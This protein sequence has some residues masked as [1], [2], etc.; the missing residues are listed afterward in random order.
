VAATPAGAAKRGGDP[1]RIVTWDSPAVSHSRFVDPSAAPEGYYQE[2]PGVD[3]RPN[4]LKADVYLPAGYATHPD[5]RYP[6]LWLLHGH[7]DS[8]DA[9]PNAGDG[10]LLNTAAGFPGLIVMPEGDHGWYAN[11]WNGGAGGD[12][13]W[14]RYHLDQL[15]PYAN[16]RLRIRHGRR[17]H[18]IAGLSMG[19]LGAMYYASQ[20]PGYFASAASF[21]GVLSQERPEWATGFNTQGEDFDTVFGGAGSFYVAGHDPTTLIDNLHSTR[22]FVSVGDGVPDPT[23][24]SEVQNYF[25]Q[26]AELELRQQATDFVGAA[27]SAGDDL[28]YT[29]HQ[30]IHTWHYWKD[31]L[32]NAI[33]WGLFDRPP[34]AHHQ[35]TYSTVATVGRMW[36]IGFRFAEPPTEVETFTRDG[37]KLSAEGSGTVTLRLPGGC[38][39]SPTLPF[40]GLVIPC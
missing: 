39:V 3:P 27:N 20:R 24:P 9:W 14:E 34:A 28:T 29:P 5:R 1:A 25:G 36:D 10:D 2:P 31:D 12:P 7:G 33:D 32:A 38:K 35:W 11:W 22:L 8:Y 30:G 6:L 4:A 37:A 21:S 13:A 16:H 15:L 18:A 17:W 26:A 40:E 19:G 23:I